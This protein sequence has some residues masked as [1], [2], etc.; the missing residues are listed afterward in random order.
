MD[1]EETGRSRSKDGRFLPEIK[2]QTIENLQHDH[3]YVTVA[4]GQLCNSMEKDDDV[5]VAYIDEDEDED[6]EEEED[7]VLEDCDDCKLVEEK[8]GFTIEGRRIVE[9]TLLGKKLDEGCLK[10]SKKLRL[11]S[12]IGETRYGLGSQLHI[13]CTKCKAVNYIPTGKV[14]GKNIWD[15]NSKLGAALLFCGLG[16]TAINNLFAAINLPH[17]SATTL[18]RRE[19]ERQALFLSLWQI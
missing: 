10:C 19:R 7:C 4:P 8:T 6:D 11:S 13:M 9:L 3:S 12:C 18:K 5:D 16:E 17:I 15:I 2:D 14:H 1:V